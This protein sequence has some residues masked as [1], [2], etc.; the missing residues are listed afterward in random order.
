MYAEKVGRDRFDLTHCWRSLIVALFFVPAIVSAEGACPPGQYPVGGQGVQGCAPIK[1]GSS[2]AA[3]SAPR[4]AGKWET[5]W[6]AIAE[7]PKTLSTG[8]SVSMKSKR[9]AEKS[10]VSECER[11]GG[12]SCKLR[13]AYHNQCVAIADPD[14]RQIARGGGRSMVISAQTIE[15]A[16]SLALE[17]CRALDGGQSCQ[18]SYSACSMSE[19]KS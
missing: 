4:P 1:A 2:G 12:V 9:Q 17:E 15:Q 8:A 16:K 13:M 18:L 10:A 6:G 5:R 7:D 3:S 19:Y 14:S 11:M